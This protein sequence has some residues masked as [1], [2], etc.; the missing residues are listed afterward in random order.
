MKRQ[1]R[2]SAATEVAIGRYWARMVSATDL[3]RTFE[4]FADAAAYPMIAAGRRR[5]THT[6]DAYRRSV[7]KAATGREAKAMAVPNLGAPRKRVTGSLAY[8]ADIGLARHRIGNGEDARI[9]L[10]ST[11]SKVLGSAKRQ[12]LNAGRQYVTGP[13]MLDSRVEAWA[14][15]SDGDPCGFCA[16]LVSRGPVYLH[17]AD[18]QAHD[19][20]GCS[21]MLV[22]KGRGREAWTDQARDFE[23][24]W[25]EEGGS[26]NN[27]RRALDDRKLSTAEAAKPS[28]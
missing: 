24:I 28:A 7:V 6:A 27:M 23:A 2:E 4:Q 25:K 26:A 14:R 19:R 3:E 21:G 22:P 16:M 20:C 8:A 15:V 12:I 17:D 11:R 1:I 13:A 18:F 9:V 10:A 5:S